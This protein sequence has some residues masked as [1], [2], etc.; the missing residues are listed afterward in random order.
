MINLKEIISA[1]RD[2]VVLSEKLSQNKEDIARV[3]SELKELESKVERLTEVV[4]KLPDAIIR[5]VREQM[6]EFQEKEAA[7]RRIALLELEN[8]F[9][10]SEKSLPSGEKKK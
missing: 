7:N 4:Q 2:Q 1:V 6:H 3:R 5:L 9:L 8:K 10:K